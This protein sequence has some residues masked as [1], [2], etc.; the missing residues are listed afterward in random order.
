MTEFKFLKREMVNCKVTGSSLI[1]VG[2]KR[3]C[4]WG[5]YCWVATGRVLNMWA[6]NIDS[7]NRQFNL[8]GK[9]SALV[10]H[11]RGGNFVFFDDDRVPADWY[12]NKL[13]YT[14]GAMPPI[15]VA[16]EWF[17]YKGDPTG[18]LEQY[19]DPKEYY[20]K[21]GQEIVTTENG[22]DFIRS[23]PDV[24]KRLEEQGYGPF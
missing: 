5:N 17:E 4:S 23:G 6:E 24:R 3:P 22:F 18:E 10:Y 8:G 16:R 9:M 1:G 7:A 21:R 14:G 2:A 20:A 11:E 19:T 12:Y 13:C 15:E